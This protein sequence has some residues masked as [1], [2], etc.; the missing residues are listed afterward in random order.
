MGKQTSNACQVALCLVCFVL[1]SPSGLS[2]RFERKDMTYQIT[3]VG[4][5][6]QVALEALVPIL[7][8]LMLCKGQPK[9]RCRSTLEQWLSSE[10][11]TVLSMHERRNSVSSA[12]V[13]WYLVSFRQFRTD[14]PDAF[15]VSVISCCS[16]FVSSFNGLSWEMQ[17]L[18]RS[19]RYVSLSD[20]WSWATR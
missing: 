15:Q 6:T 4:I 7:K 18:R 9:T 14:R 10:K 16:A 13:I 1:P 3:T 2:V 19:R 12:S 5:M 17:Y 8:S 20:S 11:N